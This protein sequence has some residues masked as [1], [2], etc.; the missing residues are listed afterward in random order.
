[1]SERS[2]GSY[3]SGAGGAARPS[4]AQIVRGETRLAEVSRTRCCSLVSPF[5]QKDL[6]VIGWNAAFLYDTA[7]GAEMAIE[8]LEYANSQC[9]SSATTTSC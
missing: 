2:P 7:A 5:I 3:C 6:A 4:I 9:S 8:L 1:M